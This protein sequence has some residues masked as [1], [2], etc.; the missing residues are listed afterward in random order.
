MIFEVGGNMKNNEYLNPD[1][2]IELIEKKL[3]VIDIKCFMKEELPNL[4]IN[5]DKNQITQFLEQQL[6]EKDR[7]LYQKINSCSYNPDD[8]ELIVDNLKLEKYTFEPYS[9]E[10]FKRY[11]EKKV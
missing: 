9:L 11:I 4:K 2:M 8:M 3:G 7:E 10:Y 6:Q 5:V 1:L